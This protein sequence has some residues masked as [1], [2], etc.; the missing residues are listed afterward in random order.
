MWWETKAATFAGE[1][2]FWSAFW[3]VETDITLRQALKRL[4]EA[5]LCCWFY[6]LCG[7]DRLEVVRNN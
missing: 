6:S 7:E 4:A 5:G 2:H 3:P 1:T